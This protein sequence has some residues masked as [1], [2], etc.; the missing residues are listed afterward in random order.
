MALWLVIPSLSK[1]K[2]FRGA[3]M[4]A[5][6]AIT[7]VAEIVLNV[8]DL[9]KMRDFYKEVLGFKLLSEACHETGPEP[10][11]DGDPTIAFLTIKGS[12]RRS[13]GMVIHSC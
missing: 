12:I 2:V 13:A 8:R 5:M 11:A 7:G 3:R 9:P 6:L 1:H 10:D 4:D